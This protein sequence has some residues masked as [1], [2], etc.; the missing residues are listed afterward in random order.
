[1]QKYLLIFISLLFS[2][3][4]QANR[5]G[6]ST[7]KWQT[8]RTTHFEIQHS[9]EHYDLGLY[10]ARI[11]ETAYQN[12]STV[13]T[14][15]PEKV[16]IV[17]N[18]STDNS[19]GYATVLPYPMIMIYPVQIGNQE[20]LSEA[21]EWARE[22]L[23]HELTHIFQ[24]YP[25]RGFYN[26]LRP[27]Y[28]SIVSPNLITPTWW[29]EGMSI[30]METQ[31]SPQGRSRSTLQN[32]TIRALVIDDQLSKFTLAEANETL[33]TWPYGNRP[34]FL[35]SL[36]MS[37]IVQDGGISAVGQ[38]VEQQS[39]RFP[40][41]VEE[42]IKNTL[43]RGYQSQFYKMIDIQ[44]AQALRQIQ[45]LK[46]IPETTGFTVD[47]NL[48]SS[49]HPRF[50]S[51][52]N[53]LAMVGFK[54]TGNEILFYKW[55]FIKNKYLPDPLQTHSISGTLGT[56]EFHPTEASI[57]F[58][59][60][61]A[62]DS[63][64]NFSDLYTYDLM[65]QTEKQITHGERAR[66]PQYSKDGK[67]ILFL[68]TSLGKIQF[69]V[70]DLN[71][72]KIES[73]YQ[74]DFNERI[75]QALDLNSNQYLLNIRDSNGEQRLITIEKS[76]KEVTPLKSNYKQI[77]FIKIKGPQIYFASTE[78]GVSNV[79]VTDADQKLFQN[80]V[81]E[82]HLLTGALSFDVNDSHIFATVIGS[83]GTQVK[84]LPHRVSRNS[85]AQKTEPLPLIQNEIANR[86]IFKNVETAKVE[87]TVDD[88]SIWPE[89]L[90]HYWFPYVATS[91]SSEGIFAQIQTAGQDPLNLHAYQVSLNYETYL[92][93]VGFDFDYLNSVYDWRF[94]ASATQSQR[95]YG[96]NSFSTLQTNTYALG[97]LPDVFKISSKLI[98]NLGVL[99]DKT[100]DGFLL[101]EHSG[102][103]FQAAYA[104]YS[105]KAAQ[106]YPMSGYGALIRYENL[107]GEKNL[108]PRLGDYSQL[109]GSII[110]YFSK[111]LPEDH[112]LMFKIDGLYTFEDVSTRFGRSITQ[113]PLIKDS[114]IPQFSA[115]GY[116][117]GQFY[118]SQL[119]TLNSEYRFPIKNIHRGSGT[120]PYFIKTLSGAV[121]VDGL[122]TKGYG[123]NEFDVLTPL[124]LS[125]QFWSLGLEAHLSTTLGYFIPLDFILGYYAPF[126][127]AYGKFAQMALSLQIGGF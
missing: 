36:L 92:K 33:K 31:F 5:V 108:G 123:V 107:K 109:A 111:W 37:E 29:K 48:L 116:Q 26:W 125:E 19:N 23:T 76:T 64:Q 25:Y 114:L 71:S 60:I 54:K 99:M 65:T 84:E 67:Y 28:G 7:E 101:T 83:S 72:K 86:Y 1:M 100:D 88:Y 4:L 91:S 61:D 8:I 21:G 127:P 50:Q 10:Y 13:F 79:Y 16:V 12:L 30:E 11:A 20:S 39:G 40:Y 69:K 34:Y 82:T 59:K 68:T 96:V 41:F 104:D 35:G 6:F 103:Y 14:Q 106:Y 77:R 119:F 45:K 66:E 55:D 90:P 121:V 3:L 122:S 24:M 58:S 74:T 110:G 38:I 120:D 73:I 126:S 43:G 57:I 51:S 95:I 102:G 115:R 17:L 52:L 85:A 118:G 93:K 75:S 117:T 63:K 49:R 113:F 46:T 89:I 15:A 78:N 124:T 32:S 44:T 80:A 112:A 62:V 53:L 70:L 42:P 87:T 18:D 47:E 22:L 56:F 81:A 94:N 9:A 98:L 2:Q 27:I 97:V 105:E